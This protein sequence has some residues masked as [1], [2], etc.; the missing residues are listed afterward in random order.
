MRLVVIA[1]CAALALPALA[2]EEVGLGLPAPSFSLRT[3]NPDV[4]GTGWLALDKF[5]GEEPEDAGSKLVV[6]SFF[7][8][9]C[10]P[11]KKEM[12]FLVQL[13]KLYREQ[14]LRIVG[15]CIDTEEPG[16]GAAKKMIAENKVTYPVVS[17]RFNF[18]ARRY[19]GESAPLPSVFLVRRDGNIARIERGYSKDV[20]AFL[21]AAIQQELG[22]KVA[23]LAETKAK[24]VPHA[25]GKAKVPPT[26]EAK[27]DPEAEAKAEPKVDSKP[28]FKVAPKVRKPA[29]KA[30]APSRTSASTAPAAATP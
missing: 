30:P 3:M 27:A 6:L 20:G 5:A 16:I 11:C 24:D 13:D 18:L 23:P 17:D 4:S 25:E 12:P 14:G 15:V 26:V 19:L 9:W 22:L 29:S 1:L 28:E 10:G 7:A 2:E 8:S 21:L